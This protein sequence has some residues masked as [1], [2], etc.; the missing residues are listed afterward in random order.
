MNH[1]RLERRLTGWYDVYQER[2]KVGRI[3]VFHIRRVRG[4]S[5]NARGR[6]TFISNDCRWLFADHRLGRLLRRIEQH[7]GVA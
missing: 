3:Y 2:M 1:L 6:W 7:Y 4:K 5:V